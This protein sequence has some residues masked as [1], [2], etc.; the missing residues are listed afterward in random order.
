MSSFILSSY[1]SP[2]RVVFFFNLK[3]SLLFEINMGRLIEFK[4][5]FDKKQKHRY[6]LVRG[7]DKNILCFVM[8]NPSVA[9]EIEDDP[10][11]SRCVF[12]MYRTGHS[13]F[14]V[15]NLF[16]H[17]FTNPKDLEDTLG[18]KGFVYDHTEENK[19]IDFAFANSKTIIAGYGVL[20]RKNKVV[21]N[22]LQDRARN[23]FKRT[24]KPIYALKITKSGFPSHPLYLPKNSKPVLYIKQT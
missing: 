24:D 2:V 7:M 11:I 13:G 22:I 8:L 17:I 21:T 18:D 10:T 16:S 6:Q 9:T 20:K 14:I 4:T 1:K 12:F 19:Y 15:V 5:Y 23:I 3:G